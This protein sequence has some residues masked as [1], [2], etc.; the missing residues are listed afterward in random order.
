MELAEA[1]RFD[2]VSVVVDASTENIDA[3]DYALQT[4][5]SNHASLGIIVWIDDDNLSVFNAL[6]PSYMRKQHDAAAKFATDLSDIAQGL[7]VNNVTVSIKKGSN[8][9]RLTE[10]V[11]CT[12]FSYDL[13]VVGSDHHN[14]AQ[15]QRAVNQANDELEVATI[16]L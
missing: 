4:A 15:I 16:V 2:M 11:Y 1:T 14:H 7:G 10:E 6:N 9:A 12:D 3:F 5:L 8:L 13:L